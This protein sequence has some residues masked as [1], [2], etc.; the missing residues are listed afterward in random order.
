MP[1]NDV[2]RRD[3]RVRQLRKMLKNGG[4]SLNTV[5]LLRELEGIHSTRL[6]RRLTVRE[7]TQ[8]FQTRFMR[9]VLQNQANR[10]RVVEIKLRCFRTNARLEQH[11]EALTKYLLA[12]YA[13]QLRRAASTKAERE[14]IV[15]SVFSKAVELQQEIR[16]VMDMSSLVIDD[17]DQTG[18]ALK[19]LITMVEIMQERGKQY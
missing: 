18:W 8:R 2:L 4:Y 17:I 6:T 15:Q 19:N 12:T 14:N 7:V 11:I 13:E 9:A 3:S 10:S 16:Q 1:L 5:D